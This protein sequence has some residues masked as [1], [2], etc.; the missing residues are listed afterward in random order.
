[1]YGRFPHPFSRFGSHVVVATG[2][3]K[4]I[5][6]IAPHSPLATGLARSQFATKSRFVSVH[7][8]VTL[9]TTVAE[10]PAADAM[11]A[12]TAARY[13]PNDAFNAV[14]PFRRGHTRRQDAD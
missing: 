12:P 8:R 6:E 2:L 4:L 7:W 5:F 9:R 10:G 3:P 1:M 13:L 11:S 14:L